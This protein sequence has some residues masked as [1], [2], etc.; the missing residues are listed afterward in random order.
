M[1]QVNCIICDQDRTKI[2]VVN[3]GF[4]LVQCL[5]DN[6][7]YVNPQ[8]DKDAI[9]RFYG[10]PEYFLSGKNELGY[11][12]YMADKE[13][14]AKNSGVVINAI[15]KFCKNG[16]FLDIGCAYGFS[17]DVARQFG[18][19]VWGNDLNREAIKYARKALNIVNAEPGYLKDI[20]YENDFFDVTMML[21][22]IE[23][24][25]NP[26]DEVGEARRILK[27]GGILAVMTVDM[28][29]IIGRGTLRPPE[30]LYYFSKRTL[31][32]LLEKN[33]FEVLN[34]APKATPHIFYFTVE[35]FFGR[36]FNYFY[37]LTEKKFLKTVILNLKKFF[38]T[39]IKRLGLSQLI[40]PGI[41]GQFLIIAKRKK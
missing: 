19:D 30:H 5:N 29:S 23:H 10:S 11:A 26:Q 20:N 37:R 32:K 38:L 21:G 6:L 7:I 14:V 9:D 18:F 1:K 24:F 22:T 12:D 33:G 39:L 2:F 34:V 3:S 27:P 17:L 25:Q 31:R 16:K 28:D 41:D 40:I 15:R 35:D 13:A 4:N 36:V 8:P